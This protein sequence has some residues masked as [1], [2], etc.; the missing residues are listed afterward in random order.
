MSIEI[1]FSNHGIEK[2]DDGEF[3]YADVRIAHAGRPSGLIKQAKSFSEVETWIND[4]ICIRISN[5]GFI[6]VEYKE[7]VTFETSVQL[8]I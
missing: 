6:S 8:L 5:T 2:N 4:D 7:E 3:N 1:I